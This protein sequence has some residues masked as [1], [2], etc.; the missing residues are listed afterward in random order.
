MRILSLLL[1]SFLF[2][3]G[4]GVRAQSSLNSPLGMWQ[5]LDDETG[6]VKSVIEIYEQNGKYYGR[7]AKI[8]TGNDDAI[9]TE[10]TGKQKDKPMLGLVIIE[11]LSKED[12]Y[13]AGG[14][15]L[16]PQKGSTYKLSAWYEDK[17]PD[18]LFIRGKHW[19][20]I[21]RTQTWRRV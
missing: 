4:T 1:C 10:C 8:L 2:L 18:R 14:T 3:L 21:F 5:T 6:E 16:D 20:G 11:G 13:W 17:N 15:I 12:D 9:C 7:V 19:T